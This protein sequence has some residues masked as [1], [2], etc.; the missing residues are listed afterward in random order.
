MSRNKG[1]LY[2][3]SRAIPTN[4]N[5]PQQQAVRGIMAALVNHWAT[6]LTEAERVAWNTYAANVTVIDAMGEPHYIPGISH[7]V[8]S[9][10]P[11][12]QAGLPRVDP[13][14]TVFNTGGFSNP[15]FTFTATTSKLNVAFTNTDDWAN[16][17]FAA[18]LVF[19]S[20]QQQN[21][22]NFFK[23]PYRF[24]G[25]I[26]GDSTTP[27]TSPAAKDAAFPVAAGNRC[28]ARIIVTS[29]DGRLSLP[30]RGFGLS[31]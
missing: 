13:G 28:F 21:T 30:F 2:L 19:S 7:Y 8:R 1:G 17:D 16:E 25:T 18:M 20:R 6:T 9:N 24:A 14:P 12:V 10:V 26:L 11:R 3:R 27:P 15:T 4:P 23:G 22:I 31:A 29:A 5:S